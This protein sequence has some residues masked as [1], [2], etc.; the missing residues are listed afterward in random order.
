MGVW[1]LPGLCACFSES[2]SSDAFFCFERHATFKDT[3]LQEIP[4][5]SRGH[6]DIPHILLRG[7]RLRPVM[8]EKGP[9]VSE[10]RS[11]P[12]F[13]GKRK[14]QGSVWG[15]LSWATR[16]CQAYSYMQQALHFLKDSFRTL[17]GRVFI[18]TT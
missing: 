16:P 18:P 1:A 9:G 13:S 15:E 8:A 7:S 11:I 5:T 14:L 6:F 4:S 17:I 3:P 12:V 10:T 2:N